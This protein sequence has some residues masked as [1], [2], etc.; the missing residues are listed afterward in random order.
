MI[1]NFL[2][3]IIRFGYVPTSGR[4]YNSRRSHPPFFA[5][6]VD[7]YY[8]ATQDKS[9]AIS[10]LNAMVKE[11]TY[12]EENYTV[13]VDGYL[14]F[15]FDDN[16][17]GPRPE[18][19]KTDKKTGNKCKSKYFK[20]QIFKQLKAASASSISFSS[21]WFIKGGSNQGD[22]SNT[23]CSY[24]IPVELNSVLFQYASI[25][26]KFAL[27][28]NDFTTNGIY[29]NKAQA[30]K[31]GI[32]D[33]LWSEE[34]GIWLDYDLINKKHRNYFSVLCLAPI[35]SGAYDQNDSAII[36]QKVVTYLQNSNIDQYPG[37]IPQTLYNSGEQ[38]DLPNVWPS[39]QYSICMALDSLKQPA[40]TKLAYKYAERFLISA[41][42]GY[43]NDGQMYEKVC[44]KDLN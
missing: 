5:A 11:Y 26:A 12:W 43:A 18:G 2:S 40:T 7:N 33:V 20:E 8:T 41:Y 32:Q 35:L 9:F 38:W 42:I 37:G 29:E 1:E 4:V 17:N 28:N 19:Y 15:I 27:L 39:G 6:M 34:V 44:T 24:I 30:L 36:A 22:L 14:L 3:L 31:N 25:I 16:T 13:S 21:K 10:C 23:Q